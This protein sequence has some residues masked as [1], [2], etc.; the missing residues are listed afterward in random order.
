MAGE[1]ACLEESHEVS[2]LAMQI[3]EDLD[4]RLELQ[5]CGFLLQHAL[6]H[7]AQL[8]ELLPMQ[9]EVG[10]VLRGVPA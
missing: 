7:A 5:H 1:V 2:E 6:C 10:P 4:G 8:V 3:P 9:K